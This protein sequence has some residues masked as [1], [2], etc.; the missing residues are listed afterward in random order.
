MPKTVEPTLLDTSCKDGFL[1]KIP[2]N[3]YKTTIFKVKVELV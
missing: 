2:L 3:T 1:C